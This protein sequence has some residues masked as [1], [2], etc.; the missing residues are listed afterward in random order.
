MNPSNTR[1]WFAAVLIGI[2]VTAVN[3]N[4]NLAKYKENP[5]RIG[6]MIESSIF[7]IVAAVFA[8]FLIRAVIKFINLGY[9]EE[10]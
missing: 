6:F 8:F 7:I 10:E 5:D 3:I 1:V 4:N 9:D 2:A